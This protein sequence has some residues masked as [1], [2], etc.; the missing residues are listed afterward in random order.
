[1]DWAV[2]VMRE[3]RVEREDSVVIPQHS[4]SYVNLCV[5]FEVE[6]KIECA[7]YGTKNRH[8]AAPKESLSILSYRR[9]QQHYMIKL[10][11]LSLI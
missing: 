2:E 6:L 8:R 9:R 5:C 10:S 4:I 7:K 11:I 3:G 1:M